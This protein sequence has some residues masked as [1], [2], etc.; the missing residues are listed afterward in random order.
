MLRDLV[1]R[2]RSYRRFYKDVPI[3][4]DTLRDLIDLARLSPSA[5]NR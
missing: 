4:L 1:L 5:A 3:P 2:N